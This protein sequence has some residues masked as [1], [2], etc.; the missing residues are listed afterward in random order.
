MMRRSGWG[1]AAAALALGWGA[2][3]C[4]PMQTGAVPGPGA[5]GQAV[6]AQDVVVVAQELYSGIED[7]RRQVIRTEAEWTAFW[8]QFHAGHVPAPAA[9]QVDF[10]RNLVVVASMGQQRTGGHEIR[11]EG[12][13]RVDDGLL[14]LVTEARPGPGC[15][16][17][18]ALV[19]P[20]VVARV[21]RVDGP[22]QFG[23]WSVVD[24]C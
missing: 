2:A 11:L 5:V 17:T 8:Q 3:A 23:T 22:V 10:T 19:Q 24:E 13:N 20:V 21:P 16:V 4:G 14:V 12:A 9:P 6:G 15:P 7:R 1:A 18:Q